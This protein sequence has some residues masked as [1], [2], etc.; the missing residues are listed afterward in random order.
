[1]RFIKVSALLV[2]AALFLSLGASSLNAKCGGMSNASP[3]AKE[4]KESEHGEA[5]GDA[6]KA[7]AAMKCGAGKCG[8][9]E[10]AKK[11]APKKAMQ[12]GAGKCG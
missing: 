3:K 10:P 5:K 1:M 2:G 9:G 4:A 12:C 7:P 8:T 6:K 11:N